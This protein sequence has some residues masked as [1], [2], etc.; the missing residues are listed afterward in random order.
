M[1]GGCSLKQPGQL[2]NYKNQVLLGT[3]L[4]FGRLTG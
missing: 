1:G 2:K 3:K 4:N